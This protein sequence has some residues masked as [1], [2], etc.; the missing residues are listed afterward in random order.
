[1]QQT[2]ENLSDLSNV[3]DT[4]T[5]ETAVGTEETAAATTSFKTVCNIL[6]ST[7]GTSFLSSCGNL[8]QSLTLPL[9][10]CAGVWWL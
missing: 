8:L 3:S 10:Q 2:Q 7:H 4:E 9:S 5:A 1:M 6:I